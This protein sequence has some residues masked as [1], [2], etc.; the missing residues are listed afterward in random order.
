MSSEAA[1]SGRID[2][3]RILGELRDISE[4]AVK[5]L[6]SDSDFQEAAFAVESFMASVASVHSVRG[7]AVR[8]LQPREAAV[9]PSLIFRVVTS[10]KDDELRYRA[11][12]EILGHKLDLT[13]NSLR[14]FPTWF[15]VRHLKKVSRERAER[16]LTATRQNSHTVGFVLTPGTKTRIKGA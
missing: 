11:F 9:Y 8:E 6:V 14:F 10:A 7:I 5:Q 3:D 4:R 2:G 12:K 13:K 1:L 16:D 15:E